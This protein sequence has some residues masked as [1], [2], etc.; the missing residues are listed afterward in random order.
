MPGAVEGERIRAVIAAKAKALN[1]SVE[2]VTRSHEQQSSLGRFIDPRDVANM[3]VF[4][5][6]DGARN[7]SGQAMVVDGHTQA[8]I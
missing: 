1:K 2:E 8:L 7:I 3:A 6:S 4:L 5:A